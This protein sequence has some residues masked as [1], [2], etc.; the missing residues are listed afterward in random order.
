MCLALLAMQVVFKNMRFV[1]L[2]VLLKQ[3][4]VSEFNML[5]GVYV[6]VTWKFSILLEN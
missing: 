1:C 6:Y 4:R 5:E 3:S 2:P